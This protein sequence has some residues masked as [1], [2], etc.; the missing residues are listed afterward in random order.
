MKLPKWARPSTRKALE[1]VRAAE[2]R[3]AEAEGDANGAANQRRRRA[4]RSRHARSTP[5]LALG[6]TNNG[7]GLGASSRSLLS[8]HGGGGGGGGGV[9]GG[10]A[11]ELVVESKEEKGVPPPP[12]SP[13]RPPAK[14]G[15]TGSVRFQ[16]EE[17]ARLQAGGEG[18][19]GVEEGAGAGAGAGEGAHGAGVG[20][21]RAK[22]PTL[23]GGRGTS[24]TPTTST[25]TRGAFAAAAPSSPSWSRSREPRVVGGTGRPVSRSSLR[26]PPVSAGAIKFDFAGLTTRSGVS[27]ASFTARS[28]VLL[29]D[30]PSIE[31]TPR[32][33]RV[34][35]VSGNAAITYRVQTGP[36]LPL[37]AHH[38]PKTPVPGTLLMSQEATPGYPFLTDDVQPGSP[39]R[40]TGGAGDNTRR[41]GFGVDAS[42]SVPSSPTNS[43]TLAPP[44]TP[45]VFPTTPGYPQGGGGSRRRTPYPSNIDDLGRVTTP[46]GAAA[47]TAAAAKRGL[48][49]EDVLRLYRHERPVDVLVLPG[50]FDSPADLAELLHPLTQVLNGT[51]FLYPSFP[52]QPGTTWDSEQAL[53]TE[54][55]A[56]SV[57]TLIDERAAAGEWGDTGLQDDDGDGDGGGGGGG[58]GDA[59][60]AVVPT[61]QRDVLLV[62]FGLG[63]NV[64]A[65]L[66]THHFQ[67]GRH[68]RLGRALRGLVLFNA[69][70]TV[71]KPL[72]KCLRRI[73]R[74]H[75]REGK[76]N[77]RAN[78]RRKRGRQ[79]SK[80][81]HGGTKKKKKPRRGSR[82]SSAGSEAEAEAAR[83]ETL[84]HLSSVLF[85]PAYL[86]KITRAQ[87]MEVYKYYHR[88]MV[89]GRPAADLGVAQLAAGARQAP[90]SLHAALAALR[91][92]VILVCSTENTLVL[93][94]HTRRIEK[95]RRRHE[96][97]PS[98]RATTLAELLAAPRDALLTHVMYFKS[99][100]QVTQERRDVVP[101]L[102]ERFIVGRMDTGVPRPPPPPPKPAPTPLAEEVAKLPPGIY[103]GPPKEK[104]VKKQAKRPTT[105]MG[106]LNAGYGGA[107]HVGTAKGQ[108][109]EKVKAQLEERNLP[110]TGSPYE[111][112][113]RLEAA[114]EAEQA[115]AAARIAASKAESRDKAAAERA[116]R[117]ADAKAARHAHRREMNRIRNQSEAEVLRAAQF[118]AQEREKQRRE[119]ALMAKEDEWVM[120][121]RRYVAQVAR[122]RHA[123]KTAKRNVRELQV[124]R[125][126]EEQEERLRKQEDERAA[127]REDR[128]RK[129]EELRE[130]IAN[131]SVELPG[132]TLGYGLDSEDFDVLAEGVV[133]LLED[134]TEMRIRQDRAVTRWRRLDTRLKALKAEKQT[135]ETELT[136]ITRAISASMREANAMLKYG[137]GEDDMDDAVIEAAKAEQEELREK[138]DDVIPILDAVRAHLTLSLGEMDGVNRNV[139]RISVAARRKETQLQTMRMKLGRMIVARRQLKRQR[140]VDQ[141]RTV[142]EVGETELAIQQGRHRLKE[143]RKEYKRVKKV[144]QRHCTTKVWQRNVTQTIK[145]AEL[146]RFLKKDIKALAKTVT[147]AENSLADKTVAAEQAGVDAA[148][149]EKAVARLK[150][151]LKSIVVMQ[152]EWE[153]ANNQNLEEGSAREIALRWNHMMERRLAEE[154][155]AVADIEDQGGI[156]HELGV[157]FA[158]KSQTRVTPESRPRLLVR[159]KPANERTPEEKAWVACDK[160]MF[161]QFYKMLSEVDEQ[162]Y[163]EDPAYRPPLSKAALLR[164][165]HLP[166]PHMSGM[167]LVRTQ[168]ELVCYD[169]I[170]T[171]SH[172]TGW[173]ML[174]LRDQRSGATTAAEA[175]MARGWVARMKL[176]E[177]RS[178]E[179]AEWVAIDRVLRP[180]LYDH[181][182]KREAAAAAR[183][184]RER[185]VRDN[186]VV[187]TTGGGANDDDDAASV[188]SGQVTMTDIRKDA[189]AHFRFLM[190][191]KKAAR[192]RKALARQRRREARRLMAD[193]DPLKYW[194]WLG[195]RRRLLRSNSVTSTASAISLSQLTSR[196]LHSVTSAASMQSAWSVDDVDA[197]LAP[198][199]TCELSQAQLRSLLRTPPVLVRSDRKRRILLLLRAYGSDD[200]A[201]IRA[202]AEKTVTPVVRD[203]HAFPDA[204]LGIQ[205]D[206]RERQEVSFLRE[207]AF[208]SVAAAAMTAAQGVV[209]LH[210]DGV[211]NLLSVTEHTLLTGQ[212]HEHVFDVPVG[213]NLTNLRVQITFRGDFDG[214]GF[215]VGRLAAGLFRL[216]LAD[217]AVVAE[218]HKVVDL[219][220]L[221]SGPAAAVLSGAVGDGAPGLS[222]PRRQ[223]WMTGGAVGGDGGGDGGDSDGDGG[224]G[225][226]DRDDGLFPSFGGVVPGGEGVVTQ[227]LKLPGLPGYTP[228]DAPGAGAGA[229]Q[230]SVRAPPPDLSI[231][232]DMVAAL[233]RVPMGYPVVPECVMNTDKQ[234]G[235]LV[236]RHEPLHLP[237]LPGRYSLQVT[238][239]ARTHYSIAVVGQRV[240]TAEQAIEAAVKNAIHAKARIPEC[241]VELEDLNFALR[242]GKWKC[243]SGVVLDRVLLCCL[244]LVLSVV[245]VWVVLWLWCWH[246]T[247]HVLVVLACDAARV[248]VCMYVCLFVCLFVCLPVCL[249]ESGRP[250]RLTKGLL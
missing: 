243:V 136:N 123:A 209:M 153:E 234:M 118:T 148:N 62:G 202:N 224:D 78:K 124:H 102:I 193:P 233:R 184:E 43:S 179:E 210:S 228:D 90:P 222:R 31:T 41:S 26:S 42:S 149:A 99:G 36:P 236:F 20:T 68:K 137:G 24:A 169:L 172:G 59:A 76:T 192:Q 49:M 6:T 126:N 159:W 105:I 27:G 53:T 244:L 207:V 208:G 34:V 115:A 128:R 2:R 212:T 154:A 84:L 157:E 138:R 55:L 9:E 48:Q 205:E 77:A 180:E 37:P 52:G 147:A 145:T 100:H 178:L 168:Q 60:A 72:D 239:L 7:G 101:Q 111:L 151:Y 232:R 240:Y 10:T 40:A 213:I 122:Q 98:T 199:F 198:V 176:P 61:T 177:Q 227:L 81:K 218:A 133:R 174:R 18:A 200:G 231:P 223:N 242:L 113:N 15:R 116:K 188:L 204:V 217:P 91:V 73:H 246:D 162:C 139:Q 94:A 197:E 127:F 160:V 146:R 211:E 38:R 79:K 28:Q 206:L 156:I 245:C 189:K 173:E 8:T 238:A 221:A 163:A 135:L 158:D 21:G 85:S 140:L 74:L 65:R 117:V 182:R 164:L 220:M 32:G 144:K 51:R 14:L 225:D 54:F 25:S 237:V 215:V 30:D 121:H 69:F 75:H 201:A 187:L 44:A 96:A 33:G 16:D 3:K 203:V 247:T 67:E 152:K 46:V 235:R 45:A 87:A 196:S 50:M 86:H 23:R 142:T 216:P 109:V 88:D 107:V 19:R 70:T 131:E 1:V 186:P 93:P 125:M 13:I 190:D 12:S 5:S 129:A 171:Y 64:A 194:K 11:A 104:V 185:K 56:Q 82:G 150:K 191:R 95:A 17:D 114:L 35:W 92:P 130:K 175:A 83:S 89:V 110:T 97:A 183:R 58:G 132:D 63:A 166:R 106:L 214:R 120:L 248:S 57:L 195:G 165:F 170:Q 219:A 141:E 112:M 167:G 161:P 4:A 47:A 143:L 80:K 108:D 226:G 29:D 155:Q 230:M 181:E 119:A 66:A 241:R 250:L 39:T 134:V 249:L 22:T 71:D 103:W 229:S